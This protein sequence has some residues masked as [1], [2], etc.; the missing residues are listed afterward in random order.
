MRLI[1][2]EFPTFSFKIRKRSHI[3]L[4]FWNPWNFF[5]SICT[6]LKWL[7]TDI[8]TLTVCAF[9]S[10]S[11]LVNALAL[12]LI[13]EL[14]LWPPYGIGQAIIFLPCGFFFYHLSSSSSF[15]LTQ[16]Q[17]SQSGCLPY[18]YT[19]C[20]LMIITVIINESVYGAVLM[21]M[22]TARVHQVHLMNADWAP[23]GRQPSDQASR[24]GLWFRR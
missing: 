1:K 19:W 15:F 21:T 14:L 20:G 16:S 7:L 6:G 24:L 10:T 18:F 12:L 3:F 9:V 11:T 4:A 13:Y 22:V 8:E 17:Q 5:G 2:W 23:G